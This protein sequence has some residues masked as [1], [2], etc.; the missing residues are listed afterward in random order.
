MLIFLLHSLLAGAGMSALAALCLEFFICKM[1][2]KVVEGWE[3]IA[4]L[5]DVSIKWDN[6]GY[7]PGWGHL[8]GSYPLMVKTT[9]FQS[10]QLAAYIQYWKGKNVRV[11]VIQ[12]CPTLCDLMGCSLPGSSVCGIV[13]D[14]WSESPL[15]ST[16]DLLDLTQVSNSGLQH[17]SCILYHLSHREAH[18]LY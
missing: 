13:Q 1:V 15:P 9:S 11:L 16:G 17:C 12:L 5:V 14:N 6:T 18:I 8:L 2:T 4:Y 7:T 10:L 3:Y